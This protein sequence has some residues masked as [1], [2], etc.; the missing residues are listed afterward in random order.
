[1]PRVKNGHITLKIT[2]RKEHQL[3][4]LKIVSCKKNSQ[5]IAFDWL[6][7]DKEFEGESRE[8]AIGKVVLN[9]AKTTER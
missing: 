9:V 5:W 3:L 7:P 8:E 6:H 1:M 4:G 2:E